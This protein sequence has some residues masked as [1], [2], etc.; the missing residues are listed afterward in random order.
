[1]QRPWA[2]SAPS[3]WLSERIAVRCLSERSTEPCRFGQ[4]REHLIPRMPGRGVSAGVSPT[5]VTVRPQSELEKKVLGAALTDARDKQLLNVAGD[6]LA[7]GA[8]HCK[9]PERLKALFETYL[10]RVARVTN[11]APV[12]FS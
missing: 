6:E 9:S 4:T 7:H 5:N 2:M 12:R 8:K 3:S 10:M 11:A 1:M